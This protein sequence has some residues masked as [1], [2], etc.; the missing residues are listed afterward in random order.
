MNE[1]QIF[2]CIE[3]KALDDSGW[4]TAYA[5]LM[6]AGATHSCAYQ[7]KR[8]GIGDAST[9]LGGIEFLG[10]MVEKVA[11]AIA[12]RSMPDDSVN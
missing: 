11:E 4:A 1:H 8:I 6:L 3:S 9:H 7:L 2:N 12:E 5:I 10:A